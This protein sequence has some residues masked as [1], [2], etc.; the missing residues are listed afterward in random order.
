VISDETG[1]GALVLANTPTLVTPLLG[2][3]TSGTLTNCTGLP[4]STGVT[5][6]LPLANIAQIAERT[7]AG[8]A[9]GAGTGD[10]TALTM[11]QI[12]TLL[13]TPSAI[14]STTNSTAWNG[15]NARIFTSTLTEN[16]TV[17]AS[18]GTP[19]DRQVVMF[20]FTQHA[21]SAKTLAWNAQ[22][23][24]GATFTNTIPAMSTTLSAISR[25][26]FVYNGTLTKYTLLAHGNH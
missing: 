13:N 15:D 20:E 9:T 24:A 11:L 22:F 21:S 17:A 10:I 23:V 14:T 3:P 26:I 5:G 18:S 25:Y 8:R 1:T 6:D 12:Q 19:F 16:T 4:L 2:T 7:L